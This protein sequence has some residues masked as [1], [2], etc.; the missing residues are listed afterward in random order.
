MVIHNSLHYWDYWTNRAT[1]ITELDPIIVAT[2]GTN[3]IFDSA[4]AG[5][6]T[7]VEESTGLSFGLC[8]EGS[9]Y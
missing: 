7:N 1:D 3:G 4:F 9:L 6:G 2:I 8:L 5:I